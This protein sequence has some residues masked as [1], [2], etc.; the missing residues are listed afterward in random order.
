VALPP[1]ITSIVATVT[2]AV[3]VTNTIEKDVECD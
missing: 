1:E 3:G 2:N